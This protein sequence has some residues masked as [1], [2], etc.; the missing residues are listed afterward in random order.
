MKILVALAISVFTLVSCKNRGAE[1]LK[2]EEA[3]EVSQEMVYESYGVEISSGN[4]LS[5]A[6]MAA[7]YQD[8]KIGDSLELSFKTRV[9]QVCKAKGC[10]MTLELPGEEEVMVRFKDYGFFVPRD[11]EQKEVLIQGKAYIREV[12]VEEQQHYA[13]DSGKTAAQIAAIDQPKRT[14]SFEAIGVLIKK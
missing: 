2:K 5:P 14:L 6:E 11:I 7:R 4:S 13:Q 10:W 3:K 12:S 8:L 9:N 1:N